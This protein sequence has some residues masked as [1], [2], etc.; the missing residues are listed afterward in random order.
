[1]GIGNVITRMQV[2]MWPEAASEIAPQ[3]D[4]LYIFLIAVS[5]FFTI[6]IGIAILF[7][8]VKYRRTSEDAVGHPVHGSTALE[9]TW[10]VIPLILVMIM[11]FWGADIF[12]KIKSPPADAME[13]LVTGKQW[14]WKLQ[15]PTGQREINN[16]HIPLGQPIKLTMTSEDVIHSFFV[17][18]FRVK[19]DVV[20]GRYTQLWFTPTKTGVYHLFCAEYCGTEHSMMG[21]FVYV[22]S[23]GDYEA[24]LSGGAGAETPA[25]AGERLFTSLGCVTC[26]H[27]KAG[28]Q[29]PN[30]AG[31]FGT[32]QP[33]DNGTTVVA[34]EDYVRESILD[35]QSKIVKGFGKVM[36]TYAGMVT[37][38]QLLNLIAYVKSIGGGGAAATP[39]P[40]ASGDPADQSATGMPAGESGQPN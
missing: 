27:G 18:A 33:L 10:S 35:P 39:E 40:Q 6:G 19:Q 7:F 12:F 8:A 29:G 1:M 15:H 11:F 16:L 30:L 9:I 28:A 34:N 21:G 5:V 13:I 14:M 22:L 38:A 26:H 32:P 2:P 17:P 3:V 4:L 24:W 23:P 20:P 37:D 31:V 36:P 25:E